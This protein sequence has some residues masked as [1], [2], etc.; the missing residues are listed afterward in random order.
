M[1][2]AKY[3]PIIRKLQTGQGMGPIRTAQLVAIVGSRIDSERGA[4]SGATSQS[5]GRHRRRA[6]SD[7]RLQQS[8]RDHAHRGTRHQRSR[9]ALKRSPLP[10]GTER[11]R[12]RRGRER[13]RRFH[14][15]RDRRH[16][17][18]LGHPR[19]LSP[20]GLVAW[21]G[22]ALDERLG[23]SQQSPVATDAADA[24]ERSSLDN[25]FLRR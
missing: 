11:C 7:R 21:T 18:A 15:E 24:Q 12:T 10:F 6:A 20:A 23:L 14:L 25:S 5:A 1:K 13:P 19:M 9:P 4:S 17:D 22:A 16:D 3:H 8:D 2:E